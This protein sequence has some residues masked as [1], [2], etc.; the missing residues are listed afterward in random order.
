[1]P[2]G[3]ENV[4]EDDEAATCPACNGE[5]VLLGALGSL[6]RYRCRACGID[7]SK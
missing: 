1:M 5:G 6:T 7:F 3:A 4:V 2:S